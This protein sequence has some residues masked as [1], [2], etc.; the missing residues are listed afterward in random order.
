MKKGGGGGA[1][2]YGERKSAAP[3]WRKWWRQWRRGAE[4]VGIHRN[5]GEKKQATEK[6][7]S[8]VHLNQASAV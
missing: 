6:A 1:L 2:A 7:A 5:E 3:V 8:S 4:N